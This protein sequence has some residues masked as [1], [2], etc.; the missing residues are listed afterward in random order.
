MIEPLH[1]VTRK[2]QEALRLEHELPDKVPNKKKEPKP[3][4]GKEEIS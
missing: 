3:W 4:A 2:D 1:L